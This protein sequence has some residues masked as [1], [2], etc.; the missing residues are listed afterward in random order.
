MNTVDYAGL[1]KQIG[2]VF[3]DKA[4][5]R[6]ALTHKSYLNECKIG[7]LECYERLEFLGDAIL[8]YIV[9]DYIYHLYPD[10]DEGALTKLRS[11]IV[12]ERTLSI[13]AREKD[14]GQYLFIGRGEEASNGR[15]RSSTMCDVFESVLGAIY[16][17]AGM[18]EARGYVERLLLCRL[19]EFVHEDYKSSLIVEC[20]KNNEKL[21]FKVLEESGP[22]HN[23]EFRIGAYIDDTLRSTGVG[24]SKKEAEQQASMAILME[25]R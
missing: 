3:S 14:F 17:D 5:L 13:I 19:D 24:R 10:T 7:K 12:C 16:L 1:E 9:T 11:Q 22:E 20:Q 15:D 21:E 8:E 25:E 18:E 4:V 6:T 2:Y 23:K